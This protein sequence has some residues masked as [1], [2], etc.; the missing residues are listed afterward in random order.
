MESDLQS[1]K[2]T[3]DILNGSVSNLSACLQE[4]KEQTTAE[5]AHIQNTINSTQ[6]SQNTQLN[7]KLDD[8]S[9][10]LDTVN[11]SFFQPRNRPQLS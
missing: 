5:V 4:H 2:K 7:D 10:K 11:T 3:L 1:L 8:L 6:S 9:S